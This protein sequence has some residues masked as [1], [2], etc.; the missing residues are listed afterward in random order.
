MVRM[1]SALVVRAGDAP[2]GAEIPF[3]V[4][5]DNGTPVLKSGTLIA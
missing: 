3:E 5:D 1:P 2:E 4:L